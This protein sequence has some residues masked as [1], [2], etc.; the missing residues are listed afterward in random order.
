MS[1]KV[2]CILLCANQILL[3]VRIHK[4]SN[5][6]RIESVNNSV[7]NPYIYCL[8]LIEYFLCVIICCTVI[9]QHTVY[10][11]NIEGE[12]L[13]NFCSFIKLQKVY[14]SIIIHMKNLKFL[15]WNMALQTWKFSQI[16]FSEYA[17]MKLL[18]L[19]TFFIW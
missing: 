9:T 18:S 19:K 1:I 2:C 10:K 16:A 7:S 12:K 17:V 8:W 15:V 13:H 6:M 4:Q 11:K 14:H 5:K 3:C